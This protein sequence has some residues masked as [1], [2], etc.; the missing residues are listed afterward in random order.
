MWHYITQDQVKATAGVSAV[1]K[2]DITQQ[3]KLIMACAANYCWK[4]VKLR[5]NH[6]LGGSAALA[7]LRTTGPELNVAVMDESNAF[8]AVVVPEWMIYYFACP[9]VLSGEVWG[10]L[11]VEQQE[12]WGR[13]TQIFPAYGRLP[14]GCSHSVQC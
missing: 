13:Y 11:R 14:M 3:R 4:D 8:T 9:P 5:T 12:T 1:A 7:K 10:R 6:G 2:K